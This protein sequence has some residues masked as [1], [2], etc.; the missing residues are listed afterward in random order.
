MAPWL[1]QLTREIGQESITDPPSQI[2]TFR[3]RKQTVYYRPPY[4]CDIPGVLYNAKGAV[5]CYPTGGF[6]GNGEIFVLAFAAL[7]KSGSSPVH[8]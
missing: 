5:L 8:S 6:A 2:L 3:Y 4:C 1:E 7:A